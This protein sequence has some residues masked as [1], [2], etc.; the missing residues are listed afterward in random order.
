MKESGESLYERVLAAGAP[1]E[2]LPPPKPPRSS[3]AVV[4]WR[5]GPGGELEV[6]WIR[7]SP[8]LSFMGGFHAFPGG[9]LSR[10]DASL[11]IRGEPSGAEAA[12]R[13]AGMPE[14]L[15]EGVELGPILPPG[16]AACALRELFEETG[17]LVTRQ[18]GEADDLPAGLVLR[19]E[20]GRSALL[21]RKSD[22]ASLVAELGWQLEAS[23]L[24]YAG[25][26]LTPPLGPLR[27]DNR[28]FLL[29]WPAS[30][31]LQP[32]IL[33]GEL[34]SGEWVRP[35]DALAR[36]G[37]GSVITAPPILYLLEVLG[38]EGPERGLE[39]LR[40]PTEANLGPHR[41]VE[42]QPGVLL[43]PL[44]TPTLPPARH[45]NA[46]ILG[47][48]EAVLVDPGSPFPEEIDRL[49]AAIEATREAL[50]RRVTAIWLTHH[51]SDHIGGVERLR[52]LLGVPVLSHALTAARLAEQGIQVD[53]ELVDGQRIVLEGD[54]PFVL[55]V[56]HTP[57][58]APGHLCF[59]DETYGSLIAGD[60]VAG[61][62]TIVVDPP[63][64][65][66]G[67]YLASLE[68]M[69]DLEPRT[70]FPG[71]GPAVQNG[72]AKL[73]ET[74]DHRLWREAKIAEAWREGLREPRELLP[75]VYS[76]VPVVAH[77]LAER[78][79]LAHLARLRSLGT[80]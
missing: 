44:P 29:E 6:F 5:R 45:T 67:Q 63:E 42:F 10:R 15:L 73:Q 77:P 80:I 51:H 28:F 25:R 14:A 74:L 54:P 33:P 23:G 62:G 59:L 18:S 60:L 66:M 53:A 64:G 47:T 3:A 30:R 76:D 65:D 8:E 32:S 39:Q 11:P 22:L 31:A 56:L 13:E 40:S 69:R 35:A 7:R 70:L 68:R 49:A 26:W 19:L 2:V 17:I 36:C 48:G 34:V 38:E 46:Y 24:V 43:F 55:R 27:F 20:E 4:L 61:F 52:Q 79:I 72:A 57:G 9:G 58:H 41:R 12:P 78:Q 37:T 75:V 50:N 21:D 1:E 16:L 71:H